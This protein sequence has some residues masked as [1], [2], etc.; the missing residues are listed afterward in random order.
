MHRLFAAFIVLLLPI[1]NAG[2]VLAVSSIAPTAPIKLTQE[3]LGKPIAVDG[4]SR[5][6]DAQFG[7]HV[8]GDGGWL[9]GQVELE[10]V[11]TAFTGHPTVEGRP[12]MVAVG[13]T[14]ELI[15]NYSGL[16][17]GQSYVWQGRVLDALG[18][19]SA[20]VPF[21]T[22]SVPAIRID[23]SPPS[24]PHI[25]SST[26]PKWGA[27][28]REANPTFHWT[29]S[30][31]GSGI[32]GYSYSFG[33]KLHAPRPPI[34][35]STSGVFVNAGNGRWYLHVWARDFAGNWSGL[36]Y[37]RFNIDRTPPK[38]VF[39]KVAA[40]NFNPYAGKQTWT[41]DLEARAH[42]VVEV[43]ATGK[44]TVL[45]QNLGVLRKGEHTFVWDGK[46]AKGQVVPKGW[47]WIRVLT[48]DKLGNEGGFASAG[49]TVDPV[50]LIYPY[51]P[52]PGRHIVIS[53]TKEA[54]YAYDGSTLV[55][56]SLV[57]TGNPAL[58]TPTGHFAIF[59]KFHPFT[60]I[61]PWPPGSPYYYPPSPVNYAMEFIS[62]GYYIHDAPWRSVYGPGSD[63]PGTP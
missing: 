24:I 21:T 20:W 23:T 34:G 35:Q 18:Q 47:Y 48:T 16:N 37:Y 30:D 15:V 32:A 58:P 39:P 41:F 44:W 19:A 38:V 13:A 26:N 52:S 5:S 12:Q 46:G 27:W 3:A 4:W 11:G 42:V 50:K 29:S 57:T 1:L 49:L 28:S 59:A 55:K 45:R 36:G 54:L 63:G 6:S 60:F 62:G 33:H 51:Y 43:E 10:K 9:H 14:A 22:G 53:L 61:S 25:T 40:T 56:W 8:Q 17:N 7:I 31:S 2:S